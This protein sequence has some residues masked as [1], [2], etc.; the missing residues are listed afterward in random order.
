MSK[1][2]VINLVISDFRISQGSV[3]TQLKWAGKPCNSY[4]ESLLRNLSIEEFWKSAYRLFAEGLMK[5]QVYCV[6]HAFRPSYTMIGITSQKP[7]KNEYFDSSS[8][9]S[10]DSHPCNRQNSP[11][12]IPV[13]GNP[14]CA[15]TSSETSFGRN[16]LSMTMTNEERICLWM[17]PFVAVIT[18]PHQDAA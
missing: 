11:W 17:R 13:V 12:G 16:R 9:L 7:A 3:A 1:S 8:L 10:H 18:S 14:C 2:S 6:G 15:S 5:R 4:I